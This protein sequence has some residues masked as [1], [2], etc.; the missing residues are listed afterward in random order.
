MNAP[1]RFGLC[2]LAIC[3]EVPRLVVRL[4]NDACATGLLVL[5]VRSAEACREERLSNL[6]AQWNIAAR[7]NPTPRLQNRCTL[8][9]NGDGSTGPASF[10]H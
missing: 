9:I 1:F 7:P 6:C 10:A 3:S 5:G 2:V 4:R 8:H